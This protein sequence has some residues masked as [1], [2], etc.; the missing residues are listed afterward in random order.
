MGWVY[1]LDTDNWGNQK[2]D[3]NYTHTDK[4]LG[5][6][7]VWLDLDMEWIDMLYN[8]LPDLYHWYSWYYNRD[9]SQQRDYCYIRINMLM[10][11][12]PPWYYKSRLGMNY[13]WWRGPC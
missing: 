13:N 11:W 3:R 4:W 8:Q 10:G 9:M 5:Y 6:G 12:Q 2:R 1:M 7:C